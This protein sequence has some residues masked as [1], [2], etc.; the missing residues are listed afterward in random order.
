MEHFI[1]KENTKEFELW[2]TSTVRSAEPVIVGE[3]FVVFN[4]NNIDGESKEYQLAFQ[5]KVNIDEV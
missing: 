4:T 1:K 5:K 3:E 2:H